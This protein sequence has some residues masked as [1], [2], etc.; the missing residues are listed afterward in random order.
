MPLYKIRFTIAHFF[1]TYRA[2][3]IATL[4]AAASAFLA[5]WL[6]QGSS[7]RWLFVFVLTETGLVLVGVTPGQYEK[8]TLFESILPS[9]HKVLELKAQDRVTIHYLASKRRQQYEQLTDYYPVASGKGRLFGFAHGIVGQCF[10]NRQSHSFS[11]PE[12]SD[13]AE[14]MKENWSFSA[15]ELVRLT[16]DRRSFFA[17]PIGRDG[18]FA[19]AVLYMDSPD[20]DTFADGRRQQIA[21][22][23]QDLFVPIF[24]QIVAR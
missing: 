14:T 20:S 18:V 5:L 7:W 1:A 17:F 12:G 19:R 15:D 24:E 6:Q 13:F 3:L 4:G 16:K 9:V 10:S 21:Q 8:T 2:V 22:K 11:I 23:I